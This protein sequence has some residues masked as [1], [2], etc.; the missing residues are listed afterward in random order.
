M[1]RF[2]LAAVDE[3]ESDRLLVVL[4]VLLGVYCPLTW[5]EA[6]LRAQAGQQAY[7]D[8]SFIGHWINR[9]L[10]YD[11]PLW[12]AHVGYLMFAA[13]VAWTF[14]RYPPR[15]FN[16]TPNKGMQERREPRTNRA[17]PSRVSFAAYAAPTGSLLPSRIRLLCE[18]PANV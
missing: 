17:G 2:P 14:R 18:R 7:T 15:R 10:Y 9:L 16:Q 1:D 13:L 11:I 12:Q 3:P 6:D 4:E 8:M 5:I